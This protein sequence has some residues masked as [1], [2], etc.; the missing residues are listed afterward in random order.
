MPVSFQDIESAAEHI[1]GYVVETPCPASI[2]LSEATGMQIYCKL[3]YLQRTG[4]FKERGARNALAL[5]DDAK[6]GRGV[7]AASAGNH[8]LGLAYHSRL[9]GIPAT[10]VMPRLA[11]TSCFTAQ[12]SARPETARWSWCGSGS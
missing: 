9:L 6:R 3:E 12:T 7:I 4:S 11:P 10:V 5:L 8:A 1:R 2:P